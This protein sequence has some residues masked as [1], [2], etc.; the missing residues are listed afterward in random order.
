MTE[1]QIID[2]A[3][4]A[5]ADALLAS[6]NDKDA[7]GAC[8]FCM[9]LLAIANGRAEPCAPGLPRVAALHRGV[10]A[11]SEGRIV[12]GKGDRRRP[13]RHVPHCTSVKHVW[14]A[15]A[16]R[17]V[18][19]ERGAGQRSVR[20]SFHYWDLPGQQPIPPDVV[21]VHPDSREYRVNDG[22]WQRGPLP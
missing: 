7:A 13:P 9:E 6:D 19:G 2:A 8:P 3:T 12:N 4:D 17:C 15:G 20:F 14:L 10:D 16:E 18:C 22:P 1:Q 21:D 11:T 5:I